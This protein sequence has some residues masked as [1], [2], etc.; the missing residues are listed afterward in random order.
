MI[1]HVADLQT[2]STSSRAPLLA[3]FFVL[4][5]YLGLT[6]FLTYPL[7]FNLDT[8]V[9]NDIGDPLL[10]TWI[11][12][13]DSHA[14]LTDPL[15][16]FNA[17]IFYPLPNTLAYSEHLFS[18]ALVALP[19]Q[20]VTAEPVVAYNLSLLLSFPLAAWGMYLLALQWTRQRSAAFIAGL[21]FAFAPYRFAAIAHLQLLTCQWLPF[22]L[23]FLDKIMGQP[24]NQPSR[25]R[26]PFRYFLALALFLLLQ[27]LASW[28]LAV[29][30]VFI[31]VIYLAAIL[32]TRRPNLTRLSLLI[33]VILLSVL[34]TLPFVWP[35]LGLIGDLQAARPLSLALSL[36]AVPTDYAAAAPFNRF[37]GPLTEI[38]RTRPNF[39][40]EN[41]LFLGLLPLLALAAV[42]LLLKGHASR[43]SYSVSAPPSKKGDHA[44]RTHPESQRPHIYALFAILIGSLLLTFPTPYAFLAAIF[45]PSTVI[46][47][48]PRWI[49]PALFALAG[50]AAFGYAMLNSK[51]KIQNSKL[52][53]IVITFILVVESLS[54]PLPLAPVDNRRTLNPAYHWLANQPDRFALIE[55][56]LH[57]A[58]DPE[59]PEVK[60]L[61]A[62]TLGWWPLVN[63][64]SGYTPPRQPRLAQ[65]LA[66]FPDQDSV[67]ALQ[68]IV[69][70]SMPSG[71][72]PSPL[73]LLVHPGEAPLDRTQWETTGRWQAERNPALF[74]L[75]QFEGDYLYQVRSLEPQQL[76]APPLATFGQVQGLRLL[77]VRLGSSPTSASQLGAG[78]DQLE[79]QQL[80]MTD[81][82][83]LL[84]YWQ[85]A[86]PLPA[87]Y[88]VFIHLRARDG[89]VRS[90][91][92]GPPVSGHYPTTNWQPGEITQDV[93]PLPATDLRQIDHLAIGLYD[94][95]TG[96]RLPAFGPNGERLVDDA[97]LVPL[98]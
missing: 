53:F 33:L 32:L 56:P 60:R 25:H 42:L 8:A 57:S 94:P 70:A 1:S 86:E 48:P 21:I 81:R 72:S 63:G 80:Q 31:M 59:F 76:I 24:A 14:L 51:L 66:S 47:V 77:A 96:E 34:I 38:F 90:Q 4:L 2:P 52:L 29:Y 49:I 28:Y 37:F 18:T 58:P 98:N 68:A 92:D 54:V 40:E 82:A 3:S 26:P 93:H 11:L 89:F 73:L 22:T 45:P 85:P 12:A 16:L 69:P 87:D 78:E 23:L 67:D 65:A 71:V 97:F 13:W 17:N 46:R 10:N 36:A 55:L 9:P 50:L 35:Y 74:P 20:F 5:I 43:V 64:Y 30:T 95:V 44:S 83:S 62:S 39:T 41:T 75:G 7:S 6:F 27:L 91:A 61:Y 19:L 88:T 15:S 79:I 84:L